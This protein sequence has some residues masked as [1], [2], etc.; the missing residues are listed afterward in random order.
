METFLRFAW[1]NLLWFYGKIPSLARQKSL[2]KLKSRV[3]SVYL[4]VAFLQAI[5]WRKPIQNT[6]GISRVKHLKSNV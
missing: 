4:K 3:C 6:K 1:R 5:I 2:T